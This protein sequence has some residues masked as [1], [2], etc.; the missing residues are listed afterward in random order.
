MIYRALKAL[1]HQAIPLDVYFGLE[2][3]VQ[4]LEQLLQRMKHVDANFQGVGETDP[5]IEEIKARR[6][7]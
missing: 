3:N 6:K 4:G 2:Q 5:N 7:S 1:G